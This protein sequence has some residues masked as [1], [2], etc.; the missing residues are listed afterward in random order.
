[1]ALLDLGSA[2]VAQQRP[3]FSGTSTHVAVYATVT[4]GGRIVTGLGVDDFQLFDDGKR[5]EITAFDNRPQPIVAVMMLDMSGSLYDRLALMRNLAG[6]FT[7]HLLPADRLRI[8]SFSSV[9]VGLS[10]EWTS[11]PDDVRR[12]L[13]TELWPG[14][15]SPVWDAIA[16]AMIAMADEDGRRVVI[17]L[18]DGKNNASLPGSRN[19]AGT[20]QETARREGNALYL[21]SPPDATLD[22]RTQE[23]AIESGGGYYQLTAGTD[24]GAVGRAIADELHQQYLLG[25]R[26]SASDGKQHS[27]VVRTADPRFRVRA[28]S[29]Y[30]AP[31]GR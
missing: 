15:F 1:M 11:N 20:I 8:G 26:P 13:T 7:A 25:F 2:V 28:R 30:I 23:L 17:A 16:T 29:T 3:L 10:A 9:Q 6:S 12:I 31:E 19:D 27:V 21:V 18:T 22:R 4:E 24:P 5:V 14:P